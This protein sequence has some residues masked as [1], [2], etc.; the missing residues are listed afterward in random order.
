MTEFERLEEEGKGTRIIEAESVKGEGYG[1]KLVCEGCGK[2]PRRKKSIYCKLCHFAAL[3]L[4]GVEEE[5]EYVP[6][7]QEMQE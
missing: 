6:T 1:P 2:R 3:A 5:K 4:A 7:A